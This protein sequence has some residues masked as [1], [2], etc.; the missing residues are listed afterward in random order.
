MACKNQDC[1]RQKW[2]DEEMLDGTIKMLE[3][4]SAIP[5]CAGCGLTHLADWLRELRMLRQE[6]SRAVEMW[7]V[8]NDTTS[9]ID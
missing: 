1:E 5:S 8:L 7:R 2:T 9:M 3:Q 6:H 4:Q